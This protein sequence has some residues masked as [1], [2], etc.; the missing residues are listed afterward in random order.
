MLEAFIVVV[1]LALTASIYYGLNTPSVHRRR[2]RNTQRRLD[3]RWE[4][5][6]K[7]RE[8]ENKKNQEETDARSE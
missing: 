1:L 6:V 5:R 8:E 7:Q 3:K 4:A 2:R